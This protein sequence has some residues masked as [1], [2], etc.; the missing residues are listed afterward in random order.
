[1][2]VPHIYPSVGYCIVYPRLGPSTTFRLISGTT[3]H[4]LFIYPSLG[5]GDTTLLEMASKVKTAKEINL[6]KAVKE[7]LKD[8]PSLMSSTVVSTE[9]VGGIDISGCYDENGNGIE[10]D[11]VENLK[12]EISVQK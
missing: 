2:P 3:P 7:A 8:C 1:M 6:E 12:A 10:S 11:C 9:A 5:V 4:F